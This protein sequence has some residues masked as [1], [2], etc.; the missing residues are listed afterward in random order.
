[1]I[2]VDANVLAYALMDG[3]A[4]AQARR[5]REID[6]DW[7]VPPLCRHEFLS[8]LATYVRRRGTT[9]A[10]ADAE[11]IALAVALDTVCV[12]SDR[13]LLRTFPAHTRSLGEFSS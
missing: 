6:P 8:V 2:V 7:R 12:T 3:P 11:F 10:R 1:M 4:T 13:Q 9:L 5:A